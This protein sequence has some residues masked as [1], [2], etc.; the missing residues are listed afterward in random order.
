M[1]GD[2][3]ATAGLEEFTSGAFALT[4]KAPSTR[5]SAGDTNPCGPRVEWHRQKETLLSTFNI[6]QAVIGSNGI[7]KRMALPAS[8]RS[9]V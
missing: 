4:A 5:P 3:L 1:L 2:R 8:T 6:G 7:E 9:S